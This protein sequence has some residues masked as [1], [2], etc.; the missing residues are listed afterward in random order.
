MSRLVDEA[1]AALEAEDWDSAVELC[2][3]ALEESPDDPRAV[4]L[5]VNAYTAMDL[6]EDAEDVVRTFLK[7]HPTHAE[8]R[9]LAAHLLIRFAEDDHDRIEEGL[10]LLEGL[11]RDK[12]EAVR[13]NALLLSGLGLSNLGELEAALQAF[14][15]AVEL[16]PEDAEARLEHG[17]ALFECARFDEANSALTELTQDEPDD[18]SAWHHLGLIAERRGE[19]DAARRFFE[20]ARRLDPEGYPPG[21]HLSEAEFD[22]AVAHAITEL[23]EQAREGLENATIRVEPLPN[24]ED[25]DGGRLSPAMVGIFHGTPV[26]ERSPMSDVDHRTAVIKLFQ[27]NLERFAQ[28]REELIEQI[29]V[30][31]LHE[32][33]HL[34][35]LDEDALY[36]RGLD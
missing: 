31:L 6:L 18:A 29:G 9:L 13:F 2:Q 17:I 35:G 27:N 23:P 34:M 3:R 26:T 21:V 28:T 25:L 20:K 16:D 14:T 11:E 24:D 30:T 8:A 15:K 36:D 5:L 22:A 19:A 32:V 12:D 7:S 4:T 33:G 1:E 10:E